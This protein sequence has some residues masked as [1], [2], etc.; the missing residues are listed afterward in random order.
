MPDE[1]TKTVRIQ[2][3]S[4]VAEDDRGRNVWVG[5]VETVE[6]E[7][8]STTALE[9]ILRS[10]D[11]QARIEI[12]RLAESGREGVLARDAAGH[13]EIVTDEELKSMVEPGA[14]APV[15]TRPR[16][17]VTGAPLTEATR[18][19]AEELSL[20]S[21][22]IL[23]KLVGADGKTSYAKPTAGEPQTGLRARTGDGGGG[24]PK[25]IGC[26]L[27]PA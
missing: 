14:E 7:L 4:R 8:V 5:K 20:V 26:D 18:E 1:F 22:Q 11:G 13:F 6:L 15:G 19:K 17:D 24:G 25:R 21:T 10:G 16:T 9:K 27:G 23:R 2:R 12:R 3:S